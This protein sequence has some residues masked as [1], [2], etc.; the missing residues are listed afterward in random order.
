MFKVLVIDN[1]AEDAKLLRGL[2]AEEGAQVQVCHDGTAARPFIEGHADG[3]TATFMLWD[4]ADPTFAE[5]LALLRH[6][7][8]ET[9][10]VVMIEEFTYELARRALNLGAADV[11]Q[12]PL[13]AE[14]VMDCYHDFLPRDDSPLMA[15]LRERIL[16]E[17][18]SL[19]AALQ[20]LERAIPHANLNVLLLG[21][22][23]TG[24]E[25][26]ARAIHDFG[27][28][29]KAPFAPVQVS[30]IPKDLFESHMFGHEK[31]AFTSADRQHIGYFEQAGDGTLFLDEIG[32][33][34]ATVQVKL[35][36]VIQE[37]E[38]W[39]L[40][41][42]EA[43]PFDA[44]LVCA[45]HH[46]L[47][48]EAGRNEFRHDLYQRISE[49]AIYVPPLRERKGDIEL[50]AWHFLNKYKGERQVAFADE[51]L[52]ILC[53]YPFPGNVRELENTVRS[54]LINCNGKIILPRHLPTHS[55]NALLP[56]PGG[57]ESD[58]ATDAPRPEHIKELTD[59]LERLLPAGWLTLTYREAFKL[60]NQAFD[61]IYLRK[62]Y[63]R[64][65]QNLKAA[66][67]TADLDPKTFRK[68]WRESGLPPLGGDE[69]ESDENR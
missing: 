44:R 28:R 25:L 68:R 30:A 17:S 36:R 15:K 22:S 32:D 3:F 29:P 47:P 69:E 64:H 5:T 53:G 12:K 7:W 26:F 4:V 9:P 46:D 66:A 21:E 34:P 43:L 58:E 18:A 61:R 59:E 14:K 50:L 27:P 48:K 33:L 6:R 57:T 42:K 65:G 31:G 45:T 56:N 67:K 60:Y 49:I 39:R 51:T 62:V 55:M 1:S 63:D 11:L 10:V 20:R 37:R 40:N 8:P 24:K 38:F 19:L 2:L 52:K 16:G 35:L 13:D 54:A 23:G 41:G